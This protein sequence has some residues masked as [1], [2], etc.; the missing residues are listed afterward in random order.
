MKLK[1]S[2][3]KQEEE[4]LVRLKSSS[5]LGSRELNSISFFSSLRFASVWALFSTSPL[6]S[7]QPKRQEALCFPKV[8]RN[9]L[10][11]FS[12]GHVGSQAQ[13]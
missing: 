10:F 5:V 1:S 3:F 11:G 12:L 7:Q 13:V 8:C 4:F 6:Q 9:F 2:L